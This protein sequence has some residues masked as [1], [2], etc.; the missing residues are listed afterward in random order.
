M[1]VYVCIAVLLGSTD[2]TDLA[3]DPDLSWHG[4]EPEA[5]SVTVDKKVRSMS[6]NR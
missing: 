6:E 1:C 5:W 3:D 2:V 4:Q